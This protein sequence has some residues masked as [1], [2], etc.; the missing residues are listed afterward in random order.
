MQALFVLLT[1]LCLIVALFALQNAAPV[2]VR[3]L[4]WQ[5]DSSV[6]VVTLAAATVGA[7]IAWLLGL[8]TRLLRWGRSRPPVPP[9]TPETP[10]PPPGI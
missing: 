7:L 3:F 8:T 4:H 1:L 10:L 6:A 9:A 2:S 5:I